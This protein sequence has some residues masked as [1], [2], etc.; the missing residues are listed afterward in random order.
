MWTTDTNP[1]LTPR[2]SYR[3]RQRIREVRYSRDRVYEI[4]PDKDYFTLDGADSTTTAVDAIDEAS[5]LYFIR[6]VPLTVGQRY[7]FN[8]YFKKDGNPITVDV[9][10]RER[11]SVPAGDFDTLVLRP[12]IS[13]SA[14]FSDQG[15]AEVWVS[16]DSHRRIIQMKSQL[17][18]G[19]IS[20]YL[21]SITDATP[22]ARYSGPYPDVALGS[23]PW[24]LDHPLVRV[25]KRLEYLLAAYERLGHAVTVERMSGG[26]SLRIV[27][28]DLDAPLT[29]RAY[30]SLTDLRQAL[31]EHV[32]S[33]TGPSLPAVLE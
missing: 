5:F 4:Y 2:V 17:S 32:R 16:A 13:T 20:L 7:V 6:T 14:L 15:R 3:F 8:R 10:R 9:E 23:P 12:T 18:V 21:H 31:E 25:M 26:W 28:G 19:S 30:G 27:R 11:I 29:V 1:G 33:G 24:H 22:L